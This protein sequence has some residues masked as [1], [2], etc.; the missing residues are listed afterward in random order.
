MLTLQIKCTSLSI[1]PTRP[2]ALCRPPC[3]CPALN[4]QSAACSLPSR[5]TSPPVH[6]RQITRSRTPL[7]ARESAPRAD[8]AAPSRCPNLY[9]IYPQREHPPSRGSRQVKQTP[10]PSSLRNLPQRVPSPAFTSECAPLPRRLDSTRSPTPTLIPP[11]R[12]GTTPLARP[13]NSH[14]CDRRQR[15]ALPRRFAATPLPRFGAAP[16][17]S[18]CGA[19]RSLHTDSVT[20][21]HARGIPRRARWVRSFADS[22]DAAAHCVLARRVADSQ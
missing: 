3:L 13:S 1:A 21:A 22:A 19:M 10:A 17:T 9:S 15:S 7:R 16:P 14:I 11:L 8:C 12:L 4:F 2:R 18:G 20:R 5:I 6:D